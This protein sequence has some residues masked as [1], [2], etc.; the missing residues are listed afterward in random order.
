MAL[1]HTIFYGS[2]RE[3]TQGAC[4]IFYSKFKDGKYETPVNIDKF[5]TPGSECGV[6]I[7]PR[8]KFVIFTAYGRPEGF[9]ITDMYISFPQKDGEWSSPQNMGAKINTAGPE[10]PL[11]VSPDGK[12]FFYIS[13]KKIHWVNIRVMD[14]FKSEAFNQ[15]SSK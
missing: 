14:A 15:K 5:N 2:Q 13:N 8:Q 7:S 10:W 12:Y 3:G 9:G 4:D 11:S 1:D 6:Y